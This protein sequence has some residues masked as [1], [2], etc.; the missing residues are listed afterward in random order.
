MPK[1]CQSH[2]ESHPEGVSVCSGERKGV[3]ATGLGSLAGRTLVLPCVT[4]RPVL[5]HDKYPL[6]FKFLSA[7]SPV[8][9]GQRYNG[10]RYIRT[11]ALRFTSSSQGHRLKE[12]ILF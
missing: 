2:E 9:C 1:N 10:D 4:S 11:V 6:W 3:L 12:M 5:G 7:G 8:T